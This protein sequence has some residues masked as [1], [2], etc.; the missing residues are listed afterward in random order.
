M[1]EIVF[2]GGILA[3]LMVAL[4][5]VREPKAEVKTIEDKPNWEVIKCEKIDQ[6][7]DTIWT[8]QTI[9]RRYA[10]Q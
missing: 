2:L 5:M 1:K 8:V 10:E 4:S 3:V 9:V 6:R 7:G